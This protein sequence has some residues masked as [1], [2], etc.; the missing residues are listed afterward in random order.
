MMNGKDI[1]KYGFLSDMHTGA[2]VSLEGSID[3]LPL[4]KFDSP[5]VFTRILGE[6]ENGCWELIPES[7][8]ETKRAYVEGTKI[9]VTEH[10]CEEGIA[11][12]FDF[13]ALETESRTLVRHVKVKSGCVRFRERLIA[14]GNYGAISPT[15]IS[16]EENYFIFKWSN[17]EVSYFSSVRGHQIRNSSLQNT[18]EM[19]AGDEMTSKL[20]YGESLTENSFKHLF[21][22]T[23]KCWKK[24]SAEIKYNGEGR[25][26]VERSALTLKAL[27]YK[28]TGAI[29]A[30]P[31]TSLPETIGGERNW[32]YRYSWLR[33][34]VFTIWAFSSVGHEAE[35]QAFFEWAIETVL[36]DPNILS[37]GYTIDGEAAECERDLIH[38]KGFSD[39]RPVRVGNSGLRQFQLDVYGEFIVCLHHCWKNKMVDLN[40][41]LDG[42]LLRLLPRLLEVCEEKDRGI[43]EVRGEPQFYT[44][45]QAMAW[46]GLERGHEILR[47]SRGGHE[48]DEDQLKMKKDRI[49]D[50]I[51]RKGVD[52]ELR[53]FTQSFATSEL[54]A[55]NLRLGLVGF[56]DPKSE[57]MVNT[58]NQTMERLYRNGGVLRYTTEDGIPVDEGYFVTCNFWLIENLALQGRTDEANKILQETIAKC[59]DL[60]LLSEEIGKDGKLLGNFPQAFS[61][62]GLINSFSALQK[63][64]K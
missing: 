21:E 45:S 57:I 46:M 4:P 6:E 16:I 63:A 24:W 13:L 2:L 40:F 19:K 59:N 58:V 1:G 11:E 9:L 31:T 30:A 56:I 44:Y 36:R 50:G 15:E 18:F 42:L 39:S 5:A 43:W 48:I 7:I 51:F 33:D 26:L 28:P 14:R 27:T 54:D 8:K 10:T 47:S 52:E 12:V 29:L 20:S 34:S 17:L 41:D 64:K 22:Q 60:G 53:C 23:L 35:A 25:T 62:I 61:H 38:L 37:V 55:A 49:L 32:D 3:W